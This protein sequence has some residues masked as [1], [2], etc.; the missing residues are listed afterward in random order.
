M[1]PSFMPHL[2]A[3][4]TPHSPTPTPAG[5]PGDHQHPVAAVLEFLFLTHPGQL[6]LLA[7]ILGLLCLFWPPIR[8]VLGPIWRF[9]TGGLVLRT[10]GPWDA[11]WLDPAP[12]RPQSRPNFRG[13][14]FPH[15]RWGR[16]PG[17]QRMA[18]RW[19][20]GFYLWALYAYPLITL[21]VTILVVVTAA[22]IQT[23]RL[24][25]D[26]GVRRTAGL[27]AAGAAGLLGYGQRDPA[28]W[29]AVPRM[30]VTPVP[31]AVS[32]RVLRTARRI[33]GVGDRL[34]HVLG[35]L[36]VPVLRVPLEDDAAEVLIRLDADLTNKAAIK[37]V[38]DLAKARLPEGP[39]QADHKEKDT[40]IRL[41]HPKRPP[42]QVWYT[43]DQNQAYAI[44][45][46]PIGQSAEKWETLPLKKL[47][48][49]TII[50]ASTGWC[51][52]TTLNV[53]VAHTSG[54][55][56]FVLINDPKRV[57][58][59]RAFGDLRN[60]RIRTTIEGWVDNVEVFCAEMQR[61]YQL[62]ERFP[63]IQ[64]DPELYFQPWF[65]VTDERGSY[66]SEI[67]SWWKN[68]MGEKGLP[69]VLRLEKLILWQGRAAA[70]Y[71][72][73]AAQQGNLEVFVDSDGRD[74]RM[75]RIASGPQTRS[76]WM[77]L[78]PGLAKVKALM[79]KGRAMLGIGPDSVTE[80]QL[81][82][83]TDEQARAF[84]E[85]GAAIAEK[86]NI[87]RKKRIQALVGDGVPAGDSMGSPGEIEGY[88]PGQRG[89]R[90]TLDA[91]SE[92]DVNG[93]WPVMNGDAGNDQETPE[94]PP[95]Y[96][97]RD[98]QQNV[99]E[100]D[101]NGDDEDLVIGLKEA[102]KL[103][104][105]NEETFKKARQRRPIPGETRRGDSP[106]WSE[107][108]LKEWRAQA[109]RTRPQASSE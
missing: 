89:D 18:A 47:A 3:T 76:S 13:E 62:I 44:D 51:K 78:F 49:H 104:G 94:R 16:L 20:I 36:W 40:V 56:G 106:A 48:P 29:I 66:T 11:T 54:N 4:P 41:T 1:T 97:V 33:P 42:S 64:D 52:T 81:A 27:F 77:M 107:L 15:T 10:P 82:Q 87:E 7:T 34:E 72:L 32:P 71:M 91:T 86:E 85:A 21:I 102:A 39:W 70:M 95:L 59:I 45:N 75:N 109:P 50:S 28:R 100:S 5:D 61:R 74:N 88:V 35:A 6:L 67:K 90:D 53:Y 12:D 46:V 83:I 9:I 99:T 43:A 65:L 79:K 17:Y 38:G 84:A 105:V 93:S 101:R 55:G 96:M 26:W 22:T 80:I 2:A 30:R 8:L 108:D 58:F 60:I 23:V 24:V 37:D 63:E 69:E 14:S 103:L 19:G 25:H 92:N 57:G 73:D 98:G 68:E 31:V